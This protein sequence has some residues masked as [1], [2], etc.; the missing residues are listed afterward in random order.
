MYAVF[1]CLALDIL[2]FMSK[3]HTPRIPTNGDIA[4]MLLL[5]ANIG[6]LMISIS[7]PIH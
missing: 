7:S 3:A 6:F 5:M 1:T 4:C 2:F